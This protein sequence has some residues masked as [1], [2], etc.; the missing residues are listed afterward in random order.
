MNYI[1]A[2][3]PVTF[4]A[5]YMMHIL[6]HHQPLWECMGALTLVSILA[7]FLTVKLIPPVQ[8]AITILYEIC[9]HCS[10]VPSMGSLLLDMMRERV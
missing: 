6:Q 4:T 5:M 10:V 7:F 9:S 2:L 1:L 8:L 3:T